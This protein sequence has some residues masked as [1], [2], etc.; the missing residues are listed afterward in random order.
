MH[1]IAAR[2]GKGRTTYNF[3]STTWSIGLSTIR[4]LTSDGTD[5]GV[6]IRSP[7]LLF[8]LT[9]ATHDVGD[10]LGCIAALETTARG[11]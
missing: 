3:R 7:T 8:V 1:A 9:D 10:V 5:W 6:L 11:R 4:I 2:V